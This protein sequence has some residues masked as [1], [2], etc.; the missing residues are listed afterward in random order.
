[1]EQKPIEGEDWTRTD[2]CI[3]VTFAETPP[4]PD[5]MVRRL[6]LLD[7][8]SVGSNRGRQVLRCSLDHGNG[9][10]QALLVKIYDPLYYNP[11]FTDATWSSEAAVYDELQRPGSTVK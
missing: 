4:H 10:D 1:M 9:H 2:W 6:R 8:I 11:T 7:E 5:Q 3:N